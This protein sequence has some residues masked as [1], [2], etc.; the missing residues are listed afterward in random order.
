MSI[1]VVIPARHNSCRI[2]NKLLIKIKNKTIIEHTI[3]RIIESEIDIPIYVITDSDDIYN[4]T[5]SLQ[6][7]KC[8]LNKVKFSNG[9]E[10]ISAN[11]DNLGKRY[12]YYLIL[13]AD[14]PYL[15]H[16]IIKEVYDFHKSLDYGKCN[17]LTIYNEISSEASTD[18][19]IAKLVLNNNDEIMYISR[20]SIPYMYD[21]SVQTLF[22]K[23]ISICIFD[24]DSLKNYHT[25]PIGKNQQIE[26]NEW[27]RFIENGYIIK[28]IRTALDNEKDLNTQD[29]LKY[30]LSKYSDL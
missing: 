3:Q 4:I 18:N 2:P 10:R 14:Q 5:N 13:H 23:H 19:S 6:N 11:I 20:Q 15:N 28:A 12:D 1:C 24:Y 7:V 17:A 8:I 22:K 29:D 9:T 16:E 27:L 25:I 21:K 26:E 30:I